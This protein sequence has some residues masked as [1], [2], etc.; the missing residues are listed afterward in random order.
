MIHCTTSKLYPLL[1]S[2]IHR[3]RDI[4]DT[5]CDFAMLHCTLS[6]IPEDLPWETLISKAGDYF[7]QFPP[8]DLAAE[9]EFIYQKG[10]SARES[11]L[12]AKRE[13]GG[14]GNAIR[15]R[16]RGGR[17]G[18]QVMTRN[19]DGVWIPL[20]QPK[21]VAARIVMWT[22]YA[23]VGAAAYAVYSAGGFG[24]LWSGP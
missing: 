20:E 4:M 2:Q 24:W 19:K 1:H 6:K 14:R 18:G 13:G 23:S 21:R 3:E 15:G 11:R 22:L 9:A 8:S 10:V 17:G 5:E 16:G 7:I 12:A